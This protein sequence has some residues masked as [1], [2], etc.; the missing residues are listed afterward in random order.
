MVSKKGFLSEIR[1]IDHKK[2]QEKED[3][4]AHKIQNLISLTRRIERPGL[5]NLIK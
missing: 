1:Y 5:T 4:P 2:V 3:G